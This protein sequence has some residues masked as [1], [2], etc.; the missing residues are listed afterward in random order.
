MLSKNEVMQ[1]TLQIFCVSVGIDVIENLRKSETESMQVK[2]HACHF[3]S[4][5]SIAQL[6][7]K[8]L[9]ICSQ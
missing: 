9:L 1:D 5:K 6:R 2:M 8:Q 7:Q 3:H 4:C